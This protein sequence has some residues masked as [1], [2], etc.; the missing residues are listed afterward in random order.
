[1]L[2]KVFARTF[3]LVLAAC[4]AAA[5]AQADQMLYGDPHTMPVITVTAQKRKENVQ[6]IPSSIGVLSD[7]AMTE[8]RINEFNE[9]SDMVPNLK[10]SNAGGATYSYFGMRGRINGT[11]DMDPTITVMVDGV[12]YDDFYSITS[13]PLFDVERVEVLRGPQSTMYGLNSEAGVI[14]VITKKPGNTPRLYLGGETGAGPKSGQ[15]WKLRGSASGP[16]VEDKLALGASFSFGREGGFIDNRAT[17]KNYNDMDTAAARL[18]AVFTPSDVFDAT[19]NLTYSKVDSD[20]GYIGLPTTSKAAG[21][22]GQ[23]KKRWKSDMNIDGDSSIEI[24]SGDLNLRFITPYAEITSITAL[25]VAD[26]DYTTDMDGTPY[27]GPTDYMLG[28]MNMMGKVD[29]SIK[30]FTEEIRIQSPQDE[31]SPLNWLVGLFYH[32]FERGLKMKIGDGSMPDYLGS[33]VDSDLRG[34]SFAIF[35]QGTYRLFDQ[36]LGLTVGLRQEWTK[37]ELK[38]HLYFHDTLESTDNQFLPKFSLDFRFTPEI[39]AYATVAKGWRTGGLYNSAVSPSSRSVV[40]YDAETSW[41]YE[42][43]A[44]TS[45]FDNRLLINAAVFQ[46]RYEDYQDIYHISFMESYLNNAGKARMMGVEIEAEARITEDLT[47]SL[48]FGFLD[49][50]YR[51]YTDEINDFSG[52]KVAGVPNFDGYLAVRYA[53]LDGCYVRP[54]MRVV[55]K[56]YWDRGN[57]H[58]QSPYMTLSMRAGYMAD[59]WEVYLYGENLTNEYSFTQAMDMLG[60]GQMYGTPIRPLE[61]GIGFNLNF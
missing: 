28:L 22:I 58:V 2:P 41:T 11:G 48:G 9:L 13:L 60:N 42:I 15:S 39:M 14:N 16:L 25:R 32:D 30:T 10:I 19:L 61:V 36:K 18:S 7:T 44:K 45:F 50:E 47:A 54:E 53:F 4:C 17:E 55:G 31:T 26:Q 38:D 20:S 8:R 56:T 34:Q 43:G 49:A 57:D 1:M 21:I 5:P 59:N 12:P 35:G 37:R 23:D 40:R 27:K 3:V 29:N 52:N 51:T 46:T 24:F 33:M 6:Q